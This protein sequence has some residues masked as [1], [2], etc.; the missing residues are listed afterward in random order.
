VAGDVQALQRSADVGTS[1][2]AD[3]LTNTA[4]D[5]VCDNKGRLSLQRR[6]PTDR[7]TT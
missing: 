1:G 6:E 5:T 2:A 4:T 3:R 7:R